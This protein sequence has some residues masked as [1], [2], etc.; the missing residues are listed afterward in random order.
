MFE[1]VQLSELMFNLYVTSSP[2]WAFS[3]NSANRPSPDGSYDLYVE[4]SGAIEQNSHYFIRYPYGVG[5]PC[6]AIETNLAPESY[7]FHNSLCY[8]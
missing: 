6:L 1:S 8:L 7:S 3:R 4:D 5:T 2:C